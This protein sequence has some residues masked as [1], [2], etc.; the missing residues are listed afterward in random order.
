VAIENSMTEHK[1]PFSIYILL[2][3]PSFSAESISNALSINPLTS[4]TVGDNIGGLQAKRTSFY[5][6]LEKAD[7]ISDLETA[8]GNVVSFL[9]RN[10]I[11]WREFIGGNGEGQIILNHT[12]YLQAE[13]G[14]KCSELFLAPALLG[15]LASCGFGLRIQGWQGDSIS[16]S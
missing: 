13:E 12:I 6:C 10:E 8:L 11:Y 4:R 3:H 5:A 7:D 1:D 15:Q 9:E 2:R 16:K 14:D